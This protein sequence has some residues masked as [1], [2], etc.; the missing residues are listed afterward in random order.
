MKRTLIIAIISIF[1]IL[2]NVSDIFAANATLFLEPAAGSYPTKGTFSLRVKVNSDGAIIN[3]GKAKISYQTDFLEVQSASKS[4][5]IFQLWPD[6]PVYSNSQGQVAFSGGVPAPGFSGIGTTLIITFKVKKEGETS[7]TISD[8]EILA[9]DGR[10]TNILISAQGGTYQFYPGVT[11]G[12][13][14]IPSGEEITV[15]VPEISVYPKIYNSGEELFYTDGKAQA[16][17]T[18]LLF[19]KQ[20]EEILRT[21]ETTSDNNGIW[22]FS[23]DEMFK[24]GEYLLSAKAKDS[25]G[26]ISESSPEYAVKIILVGFSIG[27]SIILYSFLAIILIIIVLIVTV[28]WI[29]II[30]S[31]NEKTKERLQKETK[32]AKESLENTFEELRKELS[33]KIEYFDSKQGLSPEERKL[34]DEIF[35]ILKNSEETVNKEIRDIEKELD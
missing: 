24:S 16:S 3:A 33:R 18:V 6:E 17:T 4:G 31:R 27:Q 10:G 29:N 34:R 25:N 20:G 26:N 8:A 5:S 7:V 9:A 15:P 30:F 28:V 23:T 19:L 13:E 21:W 1:F 11:S 35:Y 32:E 12:E 2:S 22:S 14:Q